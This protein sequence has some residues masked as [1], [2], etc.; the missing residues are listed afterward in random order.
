MNL[1]DTQATEKGPSTFKYILAWVLHNIL[2]WVLIAIFDGALF[3][4]IVSD[5]DDVNTYFLASAVLTVLAQVGSFIAI[6]SLFR[7]LNVKSVMYFVYILYALSAIIG[8][9]TTVNAYQE[10]GVDTTVLILS[11]PAAYLVTVFSIR[12]YFRNK[13]DRWR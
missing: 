7:S 4:A 1:P 2:A 8:V 9:S 12:R 11:V 10:I 3:K 6:Y 5:L 13:Q